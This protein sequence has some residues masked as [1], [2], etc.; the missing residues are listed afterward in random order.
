[1]QS[2]YPQSI[3]FVLRQ[4]GGYSNDAHDPGGPTNWGITIADARAY[5]KHDATAQD[6]RAMPLQ[7]AKDIYASKYWAAVSGDDLPA[8]LDLC[9]FDSGVNS[10]TGR[11]NIWL[12]KS[13]GVP[14]ASYPVMAK[15]AQ[16]V[17]DQDGAI[18][19]YCDLRLSFLH[20]LSTWRYFGTD[21]GRRVSELR[22]TAH[23]LLLQASGKTVQQVKDALATKAAQTKAKQSSALPKAIT[24]GGGSTWGAF[25]FW[26]TDA[27][28]IGIAVVALVG[29]VYLAKKVYDNAQQY[30]AYIKQIES[31]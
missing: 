27:L 15:Q 14:L 25:H 7:V 21:W 5:W 28:H 3:A 22:A 12:A 16:A 13:I 24:A 26:Q 1:M 18:N 31:L 20:A 10:G 2:S 9:T 8:G 29:F 11:S 4:E 17:K 6:V 19:K 30:T 23:T